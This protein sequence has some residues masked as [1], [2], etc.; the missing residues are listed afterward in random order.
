MAI[1]KK[2]TYESNQKEEP[3]FPQKISSTISNIKNNLL[4]ISNLKCTGNCS[5]LDER[6]NE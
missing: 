5:T 4:G 2:L 1:R 3:S 6:M